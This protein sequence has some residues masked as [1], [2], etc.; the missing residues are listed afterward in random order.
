[1]EKQNVT[2]ARKGVCLVCD[3]GL[4]RK[5]AVLPGKRGRVVREH[6]ARVGGG[7]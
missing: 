5:K 4:R 3:K 1:M 2:G 7:A 6:L